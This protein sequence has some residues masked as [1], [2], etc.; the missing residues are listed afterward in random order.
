VSPN[1]GRPRES[2]PGA[3]T[4]RTFPL[5]LHATRGVGHGRAPGAASLRPLVGRH[6][7]LPAGS[8]T[9]PLASSCS[10][11]YGRAALEREAGRVVLAPVGARNDTLDRAAYAIGRLVAGGEV[12]VEEAASA[13]LVAAER[14]GLAR[15]QAERT[16]ASG[17]RAGFAAPTSGAG[18]SPGRERVH[19]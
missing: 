18:Q 12:D 11:L 8:S 14:A 3:A 1:A 13:L 2:H 19:P 17:L 10:S 9:T 7:E 4:H 16:L 5:V 15:R 6:G